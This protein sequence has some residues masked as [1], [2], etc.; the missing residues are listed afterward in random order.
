MSVRNEEVL[1]AAE[2]YANY[3]FEEDPQFQKAAAETLTVHVASESDPKIT[4]TL[5][6]QNGVVTCNC[7]GYASYKRCKHATALEAV[8]KEKA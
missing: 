3:I 1:R 7:R 2:R 6:H 4:Y 5:H 8:L